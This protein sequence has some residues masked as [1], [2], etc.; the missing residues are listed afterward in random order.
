M[1]PRNAASPPT[2]AV[3]SIYLIAD[4]TI[5][6]SGASVRVLTAGGAWGAGAGTLSYDT[7]SGCI[8][9]TPSQGET[10]GEWFIVAVYKA[11]CTSASVTVITST[12]AVAG[13][14][15]VPNTQKVDV[16]TIKTQ[17]V[18]CGAGVTVGAFVGNATAALAVNASG[19]VTPADDSITAGK[20]DESTAYP[21]KS[22]DA[23]AT[24]VART[25]ADGDT[26]ETL[27][28]QI[29]AVPAAVETAIYTEG[30]A[31][32]LLAAIAAKV[33]E[34]LINDGDASATL[35][36]M[37]AA[38]RVELATELGRIDATISSRSSHAATDIVSGGAI[39]TASG[40]VASVAQVTG[41]VGGKVL[42]G[43]L[44]AFVGTGV[45]IDQTNIIANQTT[46][47]N[48]LG[49]WTGSGVNTILGAFK[50]LLS[51]DAS[52]PSDIGGTFDPAADSTEAVSEAVTEAKATTDKLD[53]MI[54]VVP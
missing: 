11:S 45:S 9:Y 19:H 28:D 10:N 5:Q 34:F 52:A 18:T 22:A 17:A 8:Y 40:S 48:R 15:S 14:V 12:E 24:A 25:G 2:V 39:T 4:G 27:S 6:T 7:T 42:G 37:G 38:V 13:Q 46:I 26:L 41:N 1:Y 30:D 29:D 50:A 32:A 3:G 54:E 53:S 35:A 23:G 21:L 43:G 44:G 33:E 20:F 47:M 16:E 36:A 49:A 51:K 31:T